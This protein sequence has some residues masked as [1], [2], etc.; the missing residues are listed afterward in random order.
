[1]IRDTIIKALKAGMTDEKEIDLFNLQ[2][3]MKNSHNEVVTV[4]KICR[5]NFDCVRKSALPPL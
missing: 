5:V 3:Q 1:V 2:K 4:A